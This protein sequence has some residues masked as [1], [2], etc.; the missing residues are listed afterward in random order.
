LLPLALAAG[1]SGFELHGGTHMAWSPPFDYVRDVWLP[2]LARLGVE[3]SVEL[4]NWGWYPIGKGEVRAHIRGLG[5]PRAMLKPL[6]LE[7]RG[8]LLRIFGRA[9]AANLKILIS[10]AAKKV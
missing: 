2:A 5:D 10:A 7:D 3:A 8:P 4:T 1:D 6:E 9:V